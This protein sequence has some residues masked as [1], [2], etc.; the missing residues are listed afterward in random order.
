MLVCNMLILIIL[1]LIVLLFCLLFEKTD[2]VADYL[3][4]LTKQF[5]TVDVFRLLLSV[6]SVCSD[7]EIKWNV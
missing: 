2:T 3:S 6:I 1:F 7:G 4:T 5:P